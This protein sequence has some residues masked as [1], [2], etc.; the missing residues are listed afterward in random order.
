MSTTTLL[1][2]ALT[3]LAFGLVSGRAQRSILTMPMA[4]VFFGYV[5]GEGGLHWVS[6][7]MDEGPIHLLAEITLVV[8]LFTDA[9]RID[10]KLLRRQHD[11]PVRLLSFGMP[12][13]LILG[14]VA[15]LLLLSELHFWEAALIAAIL[16]P[17]DAALGQAVVSNKKVP[18]RIRQALNVESGLNDGIA[19]P[20]VLVL[21]SIACAVQQSA[22][23]AY[24]LKFAA[25]QVTLGPLVGIAVGFIG[26]K[27][28]DR[29]SSTGWMSE[30][31]R[32]LASL[33][34]ALM[35]FSA[36]EMVHGNGF[37]AAF[38]AGLTLGN[39]SKVACDVEEFSETEGQLLTLLVFLVFGGAMLP[40]ALESATPMIWVYALVSLTVVRMVP[41]A[42]ALLGKKLHGDTVLFLGWFGPRGIASILFALLV[43]ERTAP[44]QHEALMPIVLVTVLLST[45]LHGVTAYP[46]SEIYARRHGRREAGTEEDQPVEEMPLRVPVGGTT[47]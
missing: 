30:S 41:V 27:L 28:L 43:V 15:G 26:G 2:L 5:I 45:F 38:C 25:L 14:T 37:I 34:L 4:F 18:V 19:L 47:D 42:I 7:P 9:A 3:I 16:T 10:L 8:V 33:G 44:G 20:A 31:F 6:F 46:L 35:A 24:W 29:G 13:T 40:H 1:L 12:L 32:N 11:L 17:T 23:V 36:A 21:L 39:S 22:S